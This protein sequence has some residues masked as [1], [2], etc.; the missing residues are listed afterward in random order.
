MTKKKTAGKTAKK[1]TTRR[2]AQKRRIT[3]TVYGKRYA[4]LERVAR[5]MNKTSW[6]CDNTAESV[7]ENFVLPWIEDLLDS[8]DELCG[9]IL[10]GIATSDDGPTEAPE[11]THSARIEELRAA[12]DGLGE[13][14]ISKVAALLPRPCR[15]KRTA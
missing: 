11:P 1:R 12:F 3:F 14:L 9:S 6:C 8:T 15:G 10:E 13:P 7:F 4:N 2:T 5:A